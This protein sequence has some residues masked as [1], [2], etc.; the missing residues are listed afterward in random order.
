VLDSIAA[1]LEVGLI[2]CLIRLVQCSSFPPVSA[3]GSRHDGHLKTR[4]GLMEPVE[5]VPDLQQVLRNGQPC[6]LAAVSPV[7]GPYTAVISWV[8]ARDDHTICLALDSRGI[9][10]RNVEQ[11]PAVALEILA[12]DC[13]LGV[14][15]MARAGRARIATCPFAAVVVEIDVVEIRD[16]SVRG[17]VWHGP[18][19][20]YLEGKEHRYAVEQAVLDELRNDACDGPR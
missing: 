19:Y 7:D 13:V 17:V 1:V 3:E 10:L 14:R 12:S 4:R 11:N 9:A 15:G 18:T 16:H 20:S 8:T 5:D 2:F 6:V